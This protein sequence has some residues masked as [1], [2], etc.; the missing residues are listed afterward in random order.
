M[1][2]FQREM[3]A[4]YLLLSQPQMS[5]AGCLAVLVL[6]YQINSLYIFDFLFFS[7]MRKFL[8]FANPLG[9]DWHLFSFV[10]SLKETLP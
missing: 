9:D 4:L 3:K 1:R 7:F 10:Q 8:I 5:L 6:L 2:C